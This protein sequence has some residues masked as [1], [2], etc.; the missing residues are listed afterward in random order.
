VE[1]VLAR[2][3]GLKIVLTREVDADV[4]GGAAVS[5]DN[6]VIDGTLATE[7]WR[8]RQYL[9]QTRVHGRG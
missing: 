5:L 1:R 2:R 8:I 3:T 6:Q 4:L 9:L 7:L